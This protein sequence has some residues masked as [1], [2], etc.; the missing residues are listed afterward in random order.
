MPEVFTRNMGQF[1]LALGR[2]Q[3]AETFFE[4][5]TGGRDTYLAL[6]ALARGDR[7]T[8]IR[9]LSGKRASAAGSEFNAFVLA[10]AG[11]PD[12]A[13]RVIEPYLPG[14][15]PFWVI[16]LRV[17]QAAVELARGQT[18]RAVALARQALDDP[19]FHSGRISVVRLRWI[20]TVADAL[21]AAGDYQRAA[22]VLTVAAK[23]KRETFGD[24]M[25][26][27]YWIRTQVRLAEVYRRLG[28]SADADRIDQDLSKVLA[29]ADPDFDADILS[30]TQSRAQRGR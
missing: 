14:S 27:Y 13:E 7:P 30:S 18:I 2:V 5:L 4:R 8:A 20:D 17:S 12:D 22:D 23:G 19:E 24:H 26:G 25:N 1:E 15:S 29:L 6:A 16:S 10:R 28:R 11:A 3:S 9:H 21:I